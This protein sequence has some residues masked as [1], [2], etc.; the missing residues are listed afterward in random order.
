MKQAGVKT[1]FVTDLLGAQHVRRGTEFTLRS[2][3]L[4]PFDILHSGT[5]VDA[6]I[7][8]MEG[9]IGV[10]NRV[11]MSLCALATLSID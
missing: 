1:G 2:Q 8:R 9:K 10:I 6:E 7:L 5:A 4:T 11:T 3:V